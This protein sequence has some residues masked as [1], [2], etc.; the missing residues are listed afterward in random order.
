MSCSVSLNELMILQRTS[1]AITVQWTVGEMQP[2]FPWL[3]R[4]T[5]FLKA[6]TPP[7]PHP[8]LP[9]EHIVPLFYLFLHNKEIGAW[10]LVFILTTDIEI[11]VKQWIYPSEAM[12]TLNIEK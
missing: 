10:Y 4:L 11:L 2:G 6:N 9:P 8:P 1:I 5:P 7:H 12:Y 3:W